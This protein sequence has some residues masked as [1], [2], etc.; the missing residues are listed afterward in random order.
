[1]S[2]SPSSVFFCVDA[3]FALV[4]GMCFIATHLNN[5]PALYAW[6]HP[7]GL[8]V[9]PGIW[10]LSVV[11]KHEPI[12]LN[13]TTTEAAARSH[14]GKVLYR[15]QAQGPERRDLPLSGKTH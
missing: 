4:K 10:T 13:G 9:C 8:H 3:F 7:L 15:Y 6:I 2:R 14:W 5:D 12:L 1:M 11:A